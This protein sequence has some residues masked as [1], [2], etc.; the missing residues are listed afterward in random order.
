MSPPPPAR[1]A[2]ARPDRAARWEVCLLL[3]VLLALGWLFMGLRQG[4]DPARWQ[5]DRALAPAPLV[6]FGQARVA[7]LC[8]RLSLPPRLAWR[9]SGLCRATDEADA[10]APDSFAAALQADYTALQQAIAGGLAERQSR[11]RPMARSLAEGVLPEAEA[12]TVQ[13]ITRELSAYRAHY[14]IQDPVHSLPLACAW[15]QLQAQATAASGI[16]ARA[17]AQANQLALVRGAAAQLTW[18]A[19]AGSDTWVRQAAPECQALGSPRAVVQQ[20][21]GISRRVR[22]GAVLANKS[23]GMER[24]MA[25]APWWLAAWSLLAWAL[26]SLARRTR[27][28]LRFLAVAL[29]AWAAVGALS[30]LALPAS[31]APVPWWFWLGMAAAGLL[32]QLASRS[33]RV[34]RRALFEPPP[35]GVRMSAPVAGLPLL[36]LFVGLGW[37]LTLDL[38]A[39][40]HLQNRYLG[41]RHSVTVFTVLLLVSVVP[42]LAHG[43][44]SAWVAGA[45]LVTNA[46]RPGGG[47]RWR[48]VLRPVLLSV[49]YAVG[50]VGLAAMATGWRQLTGEMLLLWLLVGVSWFFLLRAARWTGARESGLGWLAASMGPLLVHVLVVLAAL[51]V[52]DDLGPML[53]ALFA[54]AIYAGAFAAQALLVRGARWPLAGAVGLI[55]TL[56]L[57]AVLLGGLLGFA[58][59]PGESAARVAERLASVSN[60]FSAENDQLARVLW[61]GRHTPAAGWGFGAVPWCGTQAVQGGCPGVPAQ[62]Q[63]DYSFAALRAV[64]GGAG[65]FALLAAY[66]LWIAML[67]VRQASRST[68]SLSEPGPGGAARAW[69]AWLCVGWAVL[70]IVQTSVTVAGNLGVLPLTGVTWPFVSFGLWSMLHHGLVLGLVL[71]RWDPE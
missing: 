69:L 8:H 65:A 44:A 71:H 2:L 52:T 63:S 34:E 38:S 48:A 32:S 11:L 39:Q 51:V 23:A 31:G 41:L 29:P 14:R 3:G 55:A 49:M 67:A 9:W 42:M 57:I 54:S 28:P 4:L 70:V 27:R 19:S 37:W 40:G 13:A 16:E 1:G 6:G 12:Q 46:L 33:P 59:L 20:G 43:L 45:G 60:P 24:L 50:V 47:T 5:L 26:L 22:D 64:F 35:A 61:L 62:T 21:A 66:L 7:T 36:V 18:P 30:G 25:R 10:G 15:T 58:K 56:L 17:A 53:V 68:G